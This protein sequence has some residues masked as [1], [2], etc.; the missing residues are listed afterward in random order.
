M[1]F[2]MIASR[3]NLLDCSLFLLPV[4]D[5]PAVEKT[6]SIGADEAE[7]LQPLV[8]GVSNCPVSQPKCFPFA[9]R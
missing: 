1:F 2:R 7:Y 8:R 6:R 5:S 9:V 3:S 4:V